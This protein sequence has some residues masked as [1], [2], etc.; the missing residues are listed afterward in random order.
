MVAA[1]FKASMCNNI[2]KSYPT[3][4]LMAIGTTKIQ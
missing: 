4:K 3:K 2:K 1:I